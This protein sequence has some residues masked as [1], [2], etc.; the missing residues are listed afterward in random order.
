MILGP[1]ILLMSSLLGD[2]VGFLGLLH[3]LIL[4]VFVRAGD[5]L[6]QAC[7]GEGWHILWTWHLDGRSVHHELIR[8][9]RVEAKLIACLS[10]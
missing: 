7:E 4:F 6:W 5:V 2:I 8:G 3:G 1:C 9:I 10:F